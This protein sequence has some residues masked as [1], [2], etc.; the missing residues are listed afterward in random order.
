M[1]AFGANLSTFWI[2]SANSWMQTPVGG[3]FVDGK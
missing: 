3:E 1:V 2:L